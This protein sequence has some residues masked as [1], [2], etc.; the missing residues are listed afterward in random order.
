MILD[1]PQASELTR[2]MRPLLHSLFQQLPEGISEFTFANLYLFRRAHNYRI[3]HLK[4]QRYLVT[5]QDG[6]IPFFMLPFGLPD[7]KLLKEL[8]K[9]FGSMKAVSVHQSMALELMGYT[10]VEDRD[11]F[12]YLYSRK[13]LAELAGRDMHKKRNRLNTFTRNFKCLARPLLDEY[14]PHALEILEAWRATRGDAGDY[15]AAKEAIELMYELQLCG[16]I[17]YVDGRAVAFTLGEELAQGRSFVIHFE[18]AI[19]VEEYKGLYQYINQVFASMLPE[20]YETVNREQ[21]LGQP[22]LRRAKESYNP[23]GFVKKYRA[24]AG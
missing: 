4:D 3:A 13:D 1:Y 11:N 2:D 19:L 5:G 22:G 7:E 8:F 16:G 23:T 6:Q 24:I 12:D 14:I 10:A 15:D 18:K 17:Y 9:K 21:D 20:K